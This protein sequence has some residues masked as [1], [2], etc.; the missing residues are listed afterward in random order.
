MDIIGTLRIANQG[1]KKA[2][3][4]AYI[5]YP[6]SLY[7]G[8]TAAIVYCFIFW[9][10]YNLGK[11][12]LPL[13]F[14]AVAVQSVFLL[15]YG[16]VNNYFKRAESLKREYVDMFGDGIV[17]FYFLLAIPFTCSLWIQAF[18]GIRKLKID[19]TAKLF[20]FVLFALLSI[21]FAVIGFYLHVFF[22][23]GFAP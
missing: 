22:Y 1:A 12:R 10:L 17:L 11:Y 7:I 3:R 2:G 15:S 6:E 16:W 20:L 23:Y 5:F 18:Q 14:Y 9:N 13:F 19:K 8:I 21:I 4:G